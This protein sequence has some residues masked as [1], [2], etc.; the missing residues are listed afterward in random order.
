[1]S[2]DGSLGTPNPTVLVVSRQKPLV[3]D[4]NGVATWR[5]S[6]GRREGDG[7]R[8]LASDAVLGR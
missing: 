8:T 3:A 1:M 7:V 4:S 2:A 6:T 5:S